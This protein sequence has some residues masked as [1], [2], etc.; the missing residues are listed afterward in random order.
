MSNTQ[1]R[2]FI[3]KPIDPAALVAVPFR[4]LEP[5]DAVGDHEP[6]LLCRHPSALESRKLR[7]VLADFSAAKSQQEQDELL[8]GVAGVYVRGWRNMPE[9]VPAF[10]AAKPGESVA[11]VVSPEDFDRLMLAIIPQA[12]Y[13]AEMESRRAAAAVAT[14]GGGNNA[15]AGG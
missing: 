3:P 4:E 9:G 6:V 15:A 8:M 5:G 13:R 14:D 12:V 7:Q 1:T 10:D 11:S 2:S